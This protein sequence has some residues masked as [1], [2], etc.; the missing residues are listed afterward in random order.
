MRLALTAAPQAEVH[1]IAESVVIWI[2]NDSAGNRQ[3]AIDAHF[4][5]Q[6]EA[7]CSTRAFEIKAFSSRQAQHQLLGGMTEGNPELLWI[8]LHGLGGHAAER[9]ETTR[10]LFIER[11]VQKQLDLSG[12]VLVEANPGNPAWELEPMKR[13]LSDTRLHPAVMRHCNAGVVHRQSLRPSSVKTLSV[14]TIKMPSSA[15]C[16]CKRSGTGHLNNSLRDVVTL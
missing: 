13:L 1:N 3:G 7:D 9:I 11:L 4:S 10:V 15:A 2:L 5:H 14:S 8:N 12:H 6:P 16:Q